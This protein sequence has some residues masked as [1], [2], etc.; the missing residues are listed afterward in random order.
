[1]AVLN[2]APSTPTNPLILQM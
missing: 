1:M 2:K